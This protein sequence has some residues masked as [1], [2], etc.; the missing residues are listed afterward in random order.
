MMSMK[1]GH[2]GH[3]GP[4][5]AACFFGKRAHRTIYE[6]RR[7]TSG[8]IESALHKIYAYRLAA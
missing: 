6:K 8:F 5:A 1:I 7:K 2:D 3:A 4:S